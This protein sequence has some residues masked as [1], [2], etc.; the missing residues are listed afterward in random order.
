M[1]KYIFGLLKYI[2]YKRVSFFARIT[3]SSIISKKAKIYRFAKIY[4]ST[5]GDYS[6]I[7]EN[8]ELINVIVG[9]FCS[10]A[11]YCNIGLAKHTLNNIST[12]PIFTEKK[13]ATDFS[14]VEY[15]TPNHVD[16]KITIGND[17][18][19]GNKVTIL[20]GVVIGH[21]AIIGTGAIVTKDVPDYAIVVGIPAKIIRYRFKSE[22]IEE[23]L[24]LKWWDL[25]ESILKDH[26]ELFQIENI[27]MTELINLKK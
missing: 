3:P 22:I 6:Y 7:G 26:I 20:S 18:W 13:N 4:N 9:K 12:S 17:V 21:G 15:N 16:S 19:I 2:F 14:W 1:K 11:P 25:P 10:I 23:L 24:E 5:I 27:N 8:S